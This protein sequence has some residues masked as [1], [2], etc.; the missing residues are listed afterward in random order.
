M[1]PRIMQPNPWLIATSLAFI[2]PLVY[3]IYKRAYIL[4]A[5]VLTVL[6]CSTLY[7]S[8]KDPVLFWVDQIS[9]IY[10]ITALLLYSYQKLRWIGI[11]MVTAGILL[12]SVLYYY[13]WFTKSLVWSEEFKTATTAHATMHLA[14]NI[15]VCFL[16]YCAAL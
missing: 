8:T 4:V 16:T 9:V 2:I 7:H 12:N 13:G 15:G 11:S 3:G 5:G 6:V 1:D 10:L 14:T